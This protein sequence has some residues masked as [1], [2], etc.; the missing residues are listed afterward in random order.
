MDRTPVES[1]NIRSL[2][3]DPDTRLL[4][5]EFKS[6]TIYHYSGVP[7]ETHRELM[8]APSKGVYFGREIKFHYDCRK[9]SDPVRLEME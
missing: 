2:G 4:E 6:G 8:A 9:V 1:S 5:V 3:Y 7:A